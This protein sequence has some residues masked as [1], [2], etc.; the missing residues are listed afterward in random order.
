MTFL[1]LRDVRVEF[2][3]YQGSNRS[4]K[5]T[6]LA[7]T[8]FGDL[9][10]DAINRVNVVALHDLNLDIVNGDRLAIIG[11]NGAGKTT[12]LKVLA[13]IY[14]PAAGR[15][16]SSGRVTA[17]LTTSVGLNA[18]ATGRENI[19]FVECIWIFIRAKCRPVLMKSRNLLSWARIS[20][21]QYEPIRPA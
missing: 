2:P 20:I 21:C 12:L 14:Q 19:I 13:G 4:L 3:L 9:K 7:N 18:E 8:P 1:R 11:P 17:L 5:K 6:M 10:K 16:Q 15:I